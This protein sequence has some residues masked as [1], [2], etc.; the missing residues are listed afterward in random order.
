[1]PDI[2]WSDLPTYSIYDIPRLTADKINQLRSRQ[3]INV[4]DVPDD[5]QLSPK[6][7]LQV[8]LAQANRVLIDHERLASALNQLNYPLYFLDYEAFGPAIPE[9]PGYQPYQ[10]LVFQYSLHV[11]AHPEAEFEHKSF[12]SR[13]FAT[14]TEQVAA[15]LRQNIGPQGHIVVWHKTFE[16]QR[17]I[18]MGRLYPKHAEF[19][20]QLNDRIFDLR[21]VFEH[22]LYI[23]P[24]FRGGTSIKNILPILAPELSYKQLPI[25]EG[26]EAAAQWYL[27]VR[28][29]LPL[30]KQERI[31]T[32]LARYCYLDTLA[33]V[34][35]F[36]NLTKLAPTTA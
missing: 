13:D 34:K 32:N 25:R 29:N 15:S 10:H 11:I 26:T 12:L 23:D 30:D 9:L 7:R 19:M 14:A 22:Q 28:G 3:I 36:E 6:Q 20:T 1:M 27:M 2:C 16:T 33:M 8:Q 4:R 24:R 35:I 5:A 18:E 17:H 21:D 31:Y